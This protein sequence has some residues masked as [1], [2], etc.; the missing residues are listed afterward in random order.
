MTERKKF[1][2]EKV[3]ILNPNFKWSNK[4]SDTPIETQLEITTVP[5]SGEGFLEALTMY[6]ESKEVRNWSMPKCIR[7]TN[8]IDELYFNAVGVVELG[9]N[10][11]RTSHIIRK[12]LM[13]GELTG[14]NSYIFSKAIH[15]MSNYLHAVAPKHPFRTTA[16]ELFNLEQNETTWTTIQ[17]KCSEPGLLIFHECSKFFDSVKGN[18][19]FHGILSLMS[20]CDMLC[21]YEGSYCTT[22]L[23]GQPKEAGKVLSK[24]EMLELRDAGFHYPHA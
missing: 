14:N 5:L 7:D 13:Y 1:I 6:S 9:Y 2:L 20:Q 21:A 17:K 11:P 15:S 24:W 4:Y 10:I 19:L 3:S 12:A 23:F 16:V 18:N 22:D 8:T